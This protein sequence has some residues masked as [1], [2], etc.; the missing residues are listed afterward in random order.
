METHPRSEQFKPI[1]Q[2][3]KIQNGDTGNHQDLPP[4][5]GVGDLNR[6]QGRL[7]PYTNTGTFQEICEILRSGSDLPIQGTAIRVVHS[8]HGVHCNSKGGEADGHTQ[9]YKNPPVPRRLVGECQIPPGLSPAYTGSSKNVTTRL[10][11]ELRKIRTGTQAGFRLCRL[12]VRP[13]VQLGPTHTRPVAEP[14]RENTDNAIPTG[15]SGLAIHVLDRPAN[16]HI[17]T[18]SPSSTSSTAFETYTVTSQ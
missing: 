8:T 11:G 18:S 12:P 10:A 1:L 13:Q 6:H 3:S 9:G 4:T 2:G 17:E 5:R 7:L 15:L 16:S 14:S